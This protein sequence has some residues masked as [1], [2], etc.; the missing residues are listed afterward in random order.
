MIWGYASCGMK[1]GLEE[2]DEVAVAFS[3]WYSHDPEAETRLSRPRCLTAL[4]LI[5]FW[6][7]IGQCLVAV[8]SSW[9]RRLV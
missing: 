9:V 6:L 2:T 3:M 7:W 8:S 1:Q 5:R 4:A